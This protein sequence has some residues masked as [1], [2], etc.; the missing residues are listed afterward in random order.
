MLR[1]ESSHPTFI[2]ARCSRLRGFNKLKN[3]RMRVRRVRTMRLRRRIWV[4]RVRM[5]KKRIMMEITMCRQISEDVEGTHEAITHCSLTIYTQL[6]MWSE[7]DDKF[8]YNILW[9]APPGFFELLH[10]MLQFY[11]KYNTLW[12]KIWTAVMIL[13][14]LERALSNLCF[15]RCS[16]P[17]VSTDTFNYHI[18]VQLSAMP[19]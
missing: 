10:L 6:I 18:I 14:N 9:R 11:N 5:A 7:V 12:R 8:N 1:E 19:Q 13:D 15:V 4:W 3:T 16:K 17:I 2:L